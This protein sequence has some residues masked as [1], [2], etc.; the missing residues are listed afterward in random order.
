ML[1]QRRQDAKILMGLLLKTLRLGVKTGMLGNCSHFS[2]HSGFDA[3]TQRRKAFNKT[4][5][6]SRLCVND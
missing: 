1:T 6:S 3:K 2:S 4:F 5:A